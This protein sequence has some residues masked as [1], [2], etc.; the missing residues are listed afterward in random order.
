VKQG[1]VPDIWDKERAPLFEAPYPKPTLAETNRILQTLT[2]VSPV[3]NIIRVWE[4]REKAVSIL[5]EN[6][7]IAARVHMPYIHADDQNQHA[8]G[9]LCGGWNV[10]YPRATAGPNEAWHGAS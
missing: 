2:G 7:L 5:R 10:N 4:A 8:I 9:T 3:G 1:Y 6:K